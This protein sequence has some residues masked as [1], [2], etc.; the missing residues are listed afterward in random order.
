MNTEKLIHLQLVILH[1]LDAKVTDITHNDVTTAWER[2]E[3]IPLLR[4]H[5]S[6]N[7][8]FQHFDQTYEPDCLEGD[9]GNYIG[10]FQSRCSKNELHHSGLCLIAG[11]ISFALL[12]S[13]LN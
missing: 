6:S 11:A 7:E 10:A 4:K 1:L 13:K 12:T 3:V 2:S 9:L 8:K 5:Y